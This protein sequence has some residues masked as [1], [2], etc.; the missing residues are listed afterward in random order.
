MASWVSSHGHLS[1]L[2]ITVSAANSD[3]PKADPG[4][5]CQEPKETEGTLAEW[6][7]IINQTSA[8]S[9]FKSCRFAACF[10]LLKQWALKLG[11][12]VERW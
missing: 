2:D 3:I 9:H 7:K 12:V 10:E 5:I 6:G 1:W 11:G 8:S 4:E